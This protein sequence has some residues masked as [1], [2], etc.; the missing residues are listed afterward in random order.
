M[1]IKNGNLRIFWAIAALV[2][3]GMGFGYY[4]VMYDLEQIKD[5]FDTYKAADEADAVPEP[6]RRLKQRFMPPKTAKDN[7]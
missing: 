2:L 1:R 7:F 5:G 4:L 6:L 3:T